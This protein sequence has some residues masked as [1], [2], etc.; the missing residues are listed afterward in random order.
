MRRRHRL[1]SFLAGL[2]LINVL[3][4]PV[5]GCEAPVGDAGSNQ[6]LVATGHEGHGPATGSHDTTGSPMGES[7]EMPAGQMDCVAMPGC[8]SAPFLTPAVT[9]NPGG[10]SSDVVVAAA[11]HAVHRTVAPDYPPPRA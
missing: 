2:A 11:A 1:A 5:R 10:A 3:V 9:W 8:L 6:A 7:R 4:Q